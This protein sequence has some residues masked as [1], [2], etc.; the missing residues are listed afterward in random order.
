VRCTTGTGTGTGTGTKPWLAATRYQEKL[1]TGL[2]KRNGILFAALAIF[3]RHLAG[4]SHHCCMALNISWL[5]GVVGNTDR[6]GET[7]SGGSTWGDNIKVD[8]VFDV[9]GEGGV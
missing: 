2:S 9:R 7:W 8:P 6:R 1:Q 5:G 3:R 4:S